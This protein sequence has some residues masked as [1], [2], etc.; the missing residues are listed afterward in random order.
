MDFFKELPQFV[1]KV[2]PILS[3]MYGA[4]WEKRLE[5]RVPFV[6]RCFP[7][8]ILLSIHNLKF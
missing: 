1:V 7:S 5:V 3:N 4:D 6:S 8:F 2:G